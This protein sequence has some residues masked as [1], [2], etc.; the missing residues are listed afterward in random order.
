MEEDITVKLDRWK[1]FARGLSLRGRT[2]V[3]N[4]LSASKLWHRLNS[5]AVPD[6]IINAIQSK[7]VDFLWQGKHWVSKEMLYLPVCT[8][9]QGLVH[10]L[11]RIRDF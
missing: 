3:I 10:I 9:G 4:L 7:F 11:S 2:L 5:V 6:E 1:P 8:G